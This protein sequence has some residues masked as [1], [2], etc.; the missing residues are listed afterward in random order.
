MVIADVAEPL[1]TRLFTT[2]AVS[3]VW[4]KFVAPVVVTKTKSLP[5][6]N[7][8]SVPV[9]FSSVFQLAL[10]VQLPEAPPSQ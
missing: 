1:N 5:D 10:F 9:L 8:T 7:A 4:E 6:P 3:I 2:A